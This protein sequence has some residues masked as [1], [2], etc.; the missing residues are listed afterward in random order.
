M[1]EII[2]LI[3]FTLPFLSDLVDVRAYR[4]YPPSLIV[5]LKRLLVLSMKAFLAAATLWADSLY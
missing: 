4:R 5:V 3:S 2:F 1:M